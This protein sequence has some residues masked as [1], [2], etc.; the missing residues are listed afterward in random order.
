M[1]LELLS[2]SNY[3]SVNIKLAKIFGIEG[4]VYISEILNINE[5]AVR[6]NKTENDYFTLD[7]NY[8]EER[9]TFDKKKQLEI[10]NKLIKMNILK[11]DPKLVDNIFVNT[12][13]L[14]EIFG[15]TDK[16][17]LTALKKESNE[18]DKKI[19]KKK[20]AIY[21]RLCDSINTDNKE[22]SDAYKG[23]ILALLENGKPVSSPGIITTQK[24]IDEYTNRDLDMALDILSVATRRCYIDIGWAFNAYEK[25]KAE[26][27]F[28]TASKTSVP[29]TKPVKR[30]KLSNEEF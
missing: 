10:E 11:R 23:W 22:L 18:I 29:I 15:E 4:A 13:S 19:D 27:G 16:K 2:Q 26:R 8:F 21:A 20:E 25:E 12:Q 28:L 24:K 30:T 1:L 6:K 5:K 14:T 17:V 9:T 7:R 3:I